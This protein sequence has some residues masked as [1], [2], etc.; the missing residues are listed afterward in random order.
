[1]L[2]FKSLILIWGASTCIS[3]WSIS[4]LLKPGP[5]TDGHNAVQAIEADRSTHNL[6]SRQPI[7]ELETNKPLQKRSSPFATS[8]RCKEKLD[9]D[10]TKRAIAGLF[11][12]CK[13]GCAPL[14]Q[15][16]IWQVSGDVI[17]FA[18]PGL[19]SSYDKLFLT[20]E[21]RDDVC[22]EA[23]TGSAYSEA[24]HFYGPIVGIAPFAPEVDDICEDSMDHPEDRC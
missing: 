17:A 23:V 8:C 9:P 16:A 13:Y 5:K 1:M 14:N 4:N 3:A 6:Q 10:H 22:G 11:K 7:H 21:K 19:W 2:P 12:M 20:L 24:G 15:S 18:C